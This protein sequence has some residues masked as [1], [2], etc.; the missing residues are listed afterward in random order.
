[1]TTTE[2]TVTRNGGVITY[3]N[4]QSPARKRAGVTYPGRIREG[5]NVDVRPGQSV[6]LYGVL[7]NRVRRLRVC[8]VDGS[9]A[10]TTRYDQPYDLIFRIGD[11]SEHGS[12]NLIY[13]GIIVS[14]GAKTVT[15]EKDSG[16]RVRMSLY[17]FSR[18]NEDFDIERIRAQNQDT[19]LHI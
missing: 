17:D 12:Y 13:T 15:V 11:R 5:H 6:R 9:R 4:V 8:S 3:T 16:G 14:I 18:R 2:P 1:M 7:R 10:H 19:M